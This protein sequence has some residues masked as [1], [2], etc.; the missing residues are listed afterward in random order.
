VQVNK[1]KKENKNLITAKIFCEK[2]M[3]KE[4][5]WKVWTNEYEVNRMWWNEKNESEVKNK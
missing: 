4:K 5:K 2:K 3:F 1:R